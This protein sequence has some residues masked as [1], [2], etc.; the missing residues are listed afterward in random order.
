MLLPSFHP[1]GKRHKEPGGLLTERISV[2]MKARALTL[3]HHTLLKSLIRETQVN[4]AR[5]RHF[6]SFSPANIRK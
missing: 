3:N 4:T 6:T 2:Q 1:G 5:R